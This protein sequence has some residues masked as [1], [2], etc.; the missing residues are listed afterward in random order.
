M[1]SLRRV[2]AIAGIALVL[3]LAGFAQGNASGSITVRSIA[4][5][6]VE[7]GN[8]PVDVTVTGAGFVKRSVVRARVKDA[9]GA[10]VDCATS[11]D[12][13]TSL[14]A[15]L[16]ADLVAKPGTLELRVK[17]PDNSASDWIVL[18]VRTAAP[19]V[20]TPDGPRKPVVERITPT[21]VQAGSHGVY[22]T[23]FG[24]DLKDG[25]MV[26]L[27]SAGTTAEARANLA[28]RTLVFQVPAEM[29]DKPRTVLFTV[30]SPDGQTSDSVELTIV[31]A[32]PVVPDGQSIVSITQLNPSRVDMRGVR[33]ER[34]E[35]LGVGIDMKG[36]KVLLR[37]EGDNTAGKAIPVIGRTTATNGV[38]LTVEVTP[39]MLPTTGVYELRT[40][41]PDGRQSNWFRLQVTS[42]G[43]GAKAVEANVTMAVPKVVTLTTSS[44]TI[45]IEI[46]VQNVGTT[47]I[48]L[49]N[50]ALVGDDRQKVA[51]DGSIDVAEGARRSA[52]LE[53]PAPIG[54]GIKSRTPVAY[55]FTISYELSS[56][57][58]KQAPEAHS[59]PDKDALE[60]S[61]RNEITLAAIGREYTAADTQGG[62]EGWRFF[63]LDNPDN[64]DTGK[65]ADF[66][67]F[68]DSLG[69]KTRSPSDELVN[70][71]PDP[72][73]T[74]AAGLYYLTYTG[75]ELADLTKAEAKARER[76]TRLGFVSTVAAPGLVPLYR[77][78]RMQGAKPAN[79]YLT[80]E[81]DASKLPRQMQ[82]NGWK[83]DGTI[84]YVVARDTAPSP[85]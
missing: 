45:P 22:V 63:K 33:T 41:N 14:R 65:N 12:S 58:T 13:Q 30:V 21:E 54:V 10:G 26:K 80:V 55:R 42:T 82:R 17:N 15:T 85:R 20:V 39:T 2:L 11:F 71:R 23:I 83:L 52:R 70:L 76:G 3:P 66:L 50:V 44:I 69:T 79:H 5:Q 8:K 47:A 53:A 60:T 68:A 31:E 84:G 43:S 9:K 29:L 37:G 28:N 1:H 81:K 78:V 62:A 46:D 38:V 64:A 77:W 7:A 25:S 48:R 75:A 40:V 35:I 73:A 67:L 74:N 51:V 4:P 56:L 49:A 6:T 19:P 32:K 24:S 27:R 72:N 36:A 61:I 59:Y 34:I 57:T 18:E 16:P